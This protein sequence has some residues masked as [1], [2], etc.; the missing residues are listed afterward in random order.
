MALRLMQC[1][2]LSPASWMAA[3]GPQWFVGRA[4]RGIA[5]MLRGLE[6]DPDSFILHWCV[7]YSYALVGKMTEAKHH[8][9]QLDRLFPGVPYTRQLLSLIDGLEGRGEAALER[10]A[11]I[12][13]AVLDAHQWFHLAE[14]FIVAGDSS[15]G[16]TCSNAR[17]PAST[18]TATWRRTAASWIPCAA[19]RASRPFSSRRARARTRSA[20]PSRRRPAPESEPHDYADAVRLR[21]GSALSV[22]RAPCQTHSANARRFGVYGS[23]SVS[24]DRFSG[25]R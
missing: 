3:G 2:P 1:D 21:N 9:A 13:L 22:Q 23:G 11:P 12:N 17:T 25:G 6:I 10:L 18:R 7:G 16:S 24:G 20:R 8:A 15:A 4:E 5:D 14:A 19:C